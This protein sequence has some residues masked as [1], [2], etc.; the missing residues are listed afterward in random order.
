MHAALP[1]LRTIFTRHL[2]AAKPAALQ[3]AIKPAVGILD[4]GIDHRLKAF[5]AVAEGA[6]VRVTSCV[7]IVGVT[8]PWAYAARVNLDELD[9]TAGRVDVEFKVEVVGDMS[10]GI[11]SRDESRFLTEVPISGGPGLQLIRL[12]VDDVSQ[13]GAIVFRT[14]AGAIGQ[15]RVTIFEMRVNGVDLIAPRLET[16]SHLRDSEPRFDTQHDVADDEAID[17]LVDNL[18]PLPLSQFSIARLKRWMW[19]DLQRHLTGDRLRDNLLLNKFEFAT[20]R[21]VLRSYPWRLSVPFVLCNARCDFCAAWLFKGKPMPA[22]LLDSLAPVIEHATQIDMVGWGEPLIHP[23][24]GEI[25]ERLK[26]KA[27]PRARVALTTN[28]VHLFKWVDRLLDANVRDYHISIHAATAETHSDLMG[29]DPKLFPEILDAIRYLVAQRRHFDS[30]ADDHRAAA[31]P[32]DPLRLDHEPDR[33][34]DWGVQRRSVHIAAV[35]IVMQQNIA[36][37]PDFIQMCT[38]LGIDEVFFRTLVPQEVLT[39]GLNYHRLPP[40]LHPEFNRLRDR[41]VAAIAAA[42]LQIVASPE[43]WSTPVFPEALEKTIGAIPITIRAERDPITAWHGEE[44]AGGLPVG[45]I[46]LANPALHGPYVGNLT[47]NP[48]DRK[49]PLRCPSPYTSYYVNGMHRRMTPCCYMTQVPGYQEMYLKK[50]TPFEVLWN[51]QAMVALRES[52]HKGPLMQPCLK[53]PFYW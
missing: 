20:G 34:S 25:L 6:Q 2:K 8:Q 27:D 31:A 41:A 35:F 48:Y 53:C 49:A 23:E 52:L 9:V 18:W 15:P 50:D 24:F 1:R 5:V 42:R 46:D 47:E 19:D 4:Q 51:S 38:D 43:T 22:D 26:R 12:A 28:G 7:D 33:E 45:E 40:Y 37:I 36:Q 29:L 32:G 10:V 21:T 11:V 44:D 3:A 39:A 14:Y 17:P 30:R 13:A 16:P